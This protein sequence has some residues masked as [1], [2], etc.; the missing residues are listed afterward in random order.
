MKE[1]AIDIVEEC[2]YKEWDE[3]TTNRVNKWIEAVL[4]MQDPKTYTGGSPKVQVAD[5]KPE[6]TTSES[7]VDAMMDE[8]LPF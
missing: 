6:S 2:A 3:N 5:T 1:N 4:D 8:E 7:A